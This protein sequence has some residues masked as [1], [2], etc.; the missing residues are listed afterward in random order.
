MAETNGCK[1]LE[2]LLKA[3]IPLIKRHL[4]KHKWYKHIENSEEATADFIK[5]YGFIMREMY[6]S[7]ICINKDGCELIKEYLKQ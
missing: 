4:E 5:N 1:H 2:D 3:E 7:N 6:C